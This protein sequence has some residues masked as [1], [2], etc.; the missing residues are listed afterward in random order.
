MLEPRIPETRLQRQSP[1]EGQL[2]QGPLLFATVTIKARP[3]LEIA[4]IGLFSRSI[5]AHG[6]FGHQLARCLS[7]TMPPEANRAVQSG[8]DL[9]MMA[10]APGRWWVVGDDGSSVRELLTKADPK[11]LPIDQSIIIDQSHGRAVLRL[12]GKGVRGLLNCGTAI[13]LRDAAFTPNMIAQTRLSH[14]SVLVDCLEHDCFD[15][16]IPRSFARSALHWLCARA[17]S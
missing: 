6:Q 4:E 9:R 16:Y 1:F 14:Y 3:D 7:I 11:I 2:T 8:D 17:A 15:L 13:D 12:E 5:T 10:L